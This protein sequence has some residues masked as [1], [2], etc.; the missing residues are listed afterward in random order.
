MLKHQ[1]L[2]D[3]DELVVMSLDRLSRNKM[4]IK[5]EL[6][7]YKQHHI[8][9]KVLDMPTTLVELSDEQDWI[10]DMINNILIED[11]ASIAEQERVR[12]HQRQAGEITVVAAM[13][14]LK[15]K[16]ADSINWLLL[17]DGKQSKNKIKNSAGGYDHRRYSLILRKA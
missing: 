13:A 14:E 9:V 2:R 12:T 3:G 15:M 8:R 16:K 6:E 7:Y 11:M 5:N 10:F 4:H 1:M 17:C